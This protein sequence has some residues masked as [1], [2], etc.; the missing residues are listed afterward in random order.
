MRSG[1]LRKVDFYRLARPVQDRFSAASRGTAPPAP[2][3]FRAAPRT[4]AWASLGASAVLVLVASLLLR[5]GMGDPTSTLALHGVKMLAVDVLLLGAAAY[6][7]VHA[8][9]IL[10]ALDASPYRPGLY[11][12][13]ACVVD[14]RQ[15]GFR[16]WSVAEAD[17]VEVVSAPGPGV[18]L[19]FARGAGV[20]VPAPNA[21]AAQRAEAA[22]AS[23]KADLGRAI[24]QD[25]IH[26]MADLDPLHEGAM[27]SP[28]GPTESMRHVIPLWIRL[29][30]AIAAAV[31]VAL[32]VVLGETRN[33]VSDDAMYG[34]IT[35][36]AT[37]A[38]YEQY[39][40]RGGR[41]SDEVR[42]VLLP[43]AELAEAE[44]QGTVEAVQAFA[45]SHAG[46]RIG[47]EIDAAMRRALLARLDKAKREGTVT[48]LDQFTRTYPDSKL[49]A[50]L[51]AARHALF[52]QALANWRKT[53]KPDASAAPL[54][55]R[56]LAFSEKSGSPTCEVRFR[57]RP[58]KSLD[59]GDKKI[60]TSG[61][62]P[63]PDA[64]PSAHVS[65]T[66]MRPREQ[67]VAEDVAQRFAANF[68]ADILAM[69]AGETLA[70]DAAPPGNVPTLVIEYA[71]EW[72]RT[73]V[74]TVKPATVFANM[75]FYF[76]ATFAV[77]DGA[78]P[79]KISTHAWRGAETWRLKG[80]GLSREEYETQIYD[81]MIDGAFDHVEKRLLNAFF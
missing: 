58:S 4:A 51:K 28:I 29:D 35:A 48:A 69:H 38:S 16:V 18:A 10:R 13:P 76:D 17:A 66:A 60:M 57:L 52:A 25:D 22:L 55:E 80:D 9:A 23:F 6:G 61:H 33:S 27:S 15:S 64:L 30:W 49:D 31:G 75:M 63:G 7:V 42:E 32:G 70:A 45:A 39:I 68:P 50:E 74:V 41:H 54:V 81:A 12:F 14:A 67:R 3:L 8:M 21:G 36:A 56:L 47:P 40:A 1:T 11:L 26:L 44:A 53:A 37:T 46:T 19:R 77:P 65:V 34:A 2:L 59:E 72:G 79:L 20:V 5:A 62:F 43:R 73:N 24:S 78:A 71:P